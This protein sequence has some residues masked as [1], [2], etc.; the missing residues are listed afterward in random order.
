[1]LRITRKHEIYIGEVR[2]MVRL[3]MANYNEC[4]VYL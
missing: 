3:A 2:V 1:M 4:S